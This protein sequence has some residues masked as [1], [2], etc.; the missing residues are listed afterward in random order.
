MMKKCLLFIGIL[1]LF[2][3]G[4]PGCGNDT[5]TAKKEVIRPV[6]VITVSAGSSSNDPNTYSTVARGIHES[7]LSFRVPGVLQTLQVNVGDKVKAQQVAA[8]V[9]DRDYKLRVEDVRY[10]LKA[11]QA[12]FEQLQKGVRSEDL[13]I[14]DNKI[15]ALKSSAKTIETDY[16]R[17]QQLYA[18]DAASKSQ[19]DNAK[20]RFDQIQ[21][22]LKG[23]QEERIKA[24]TG[25]REEEVR[26]S[27]ANLRSIRSNL[28]QA[29]AS[30]EDTSLKIPFDGIIS[31]KHVSNFQQIGAGT[32]IYTLVDIS[33]VELQVSVP[34]SLINSISSG[35]EVVVDFLN[36]AKTHF[37][38][39][40]TKVGVSADRQTMTYPVFI[41]VDNPNLIILPGMTAR[42][43]LKSARGGQNFPFVP[44]HSILEDKVSK[45]RYVWV[46]DKADSTVK[47]REIALG[48][49]MVNEIEVLQGLADGDIVVVAGAHRIKEGMKVRLPR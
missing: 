13:R 8:T 6:K 35:Q 3:I 45:A 9:D 28:S 23:A 48:R 22:D 12:Q 24:T 5:E 11:A 42:V 32:I 40:V 29:E 10:K 31:Q 20:T 21:A 34:E 19:L 46:F 38:G 27:R 2:S 16:K 41:E 49:I 39:K 36:F 26:A 18:A 44:I 7:V 47:R 17:V 30:L 33:R 15:R 1:C 14:I 37:T 25:G 4:L 43:M